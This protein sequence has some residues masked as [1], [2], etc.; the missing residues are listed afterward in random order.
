MQ[1]IMVTVVVVREVLLFLGL[2]TQAKTSEASLLLQTE[3]GLRN[4][5]KGDFVNISKRLNKYAD[6]YHPRCDAIHFGR[7]VNKFERNTSTAFTPSRL[8]Q[9]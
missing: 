7:S 6:C 4:F 5:V 9:R 1:N 3:A 8:A 2:S